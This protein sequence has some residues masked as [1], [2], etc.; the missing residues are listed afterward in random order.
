MK[1][2]LWLSLIAL[3]G[4]VETKE[5]E[6]DTADGTTDA[7]SATVASVTPA[8]GEEGVSVSNA[9]VVTFSE[10]RSD[11]S[12][13]L[14]GVAG[15]VTAS[16]DGLSVTFT[17][18]APLEADTTYTVTASICGVV[19][20]STFTT[21]SAWGVDI[22]GRTY[23]I[24]LGGSDV[25]WIQPSGGSLLAGLLETPY[26]LVMVESSGSELDLLGAAGW[27][28]DGNVEQYPDAPA[29][30]FA[31]ADFS[32]APAFTSPPTDAS[33]S[34]SGT[35][36]TIYDLALSGTF[37]EDGSSWDTLHLSGMLDSVTLDAYVEASLGLAT[38]D[39]IGLLGGTCVA[40]PGD[41]SGEIRCVP[42]ELEDG[43]A[44]WVEGLTL[45]AE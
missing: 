33:L 12:V 24:D 7:C 26:I 16:E 40:C 43:S 14:D 11:A 13:S 21:A 20:T 17:P 22:T 30:D 10:A 25:Q 5:T 37:S 3:T 2:I 41:D 6:T 44:P 27:E 39:A 38:C 34:V 31:P 15:S 9:V 1:N 28:V 4:C 32:T 42:L 23:A 19:T 45:T 8:D 35:T 18:D 29:I 36:V